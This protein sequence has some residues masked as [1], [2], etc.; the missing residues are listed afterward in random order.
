MILAAGVWRDGYHIDIRGGGVDWILTRGSDT[1]EMI[2]CRLP[3]GSVC[4][5][6]GDGRGLGLFR[7]CGM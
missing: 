1:A 7:R 2:W 3:G 5:N 6:D 4:N